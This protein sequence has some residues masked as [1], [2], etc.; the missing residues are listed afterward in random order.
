MANRHAPG[1]KSRPRIVGSAQRAQAQQARRTKKTHVG[2]SVDNWLREEGLYEQTTSRAIKRVLARQLQAAMHAQNVS[3]VEM[4]RRMGSS[5]SAL[6][7]LLDPA[8]DSV[9]LGTLRKAAA[10]VG[11]E[12]RLELV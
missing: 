10:A 12:V 5:R 3:K 7:R 2:S 6:D 1:A 8:N 11:L 4:A 9:T